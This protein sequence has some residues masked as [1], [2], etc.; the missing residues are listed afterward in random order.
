MRKL[1]CAI[2]CAVLAALS[3]AQGGNETGPPAQ[4]GG[5]YV[6]EPPPPPP[7]PQPSSA[8][9]ARIGFR[10]DERGTI[11]EISARGEPG[12]AFLAGMVRP[13]SS[14]PVV[15]TTGQLDA[16][17][18]WAFEKVLTTQQLEAL[19]HVEFVFAGR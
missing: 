17:G 10:Q 19:A 1:I 9:V 5:Q 7:P 13:G 14:R 12:Q 6:F 4:A 8:V 16:D 18:K 15:L 3:F 11:L 2:S